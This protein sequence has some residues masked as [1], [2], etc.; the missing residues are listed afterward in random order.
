MELIRIK[1]NIMTWQFL[2]LVARTKLRGSFRK[3]NFVGIFICMDLMIFTELSPCK[4]ASKRNSVLKRQ[5]NPMIQSLK[6]N[7]CVH[8]LA[9][10]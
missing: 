7:L 3:Y 5:T 1:Y 2:S 6:M 9:L 10:T 4:E 8:Y